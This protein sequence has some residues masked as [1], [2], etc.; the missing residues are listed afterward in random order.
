[1]S[2]SGLE[3]AAGRTEEF[4]RSARMNLSSLC[5]YR[6]LVEAGIGLAIVSL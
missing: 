2:M 1:M 6:Q 5:S 4:E 3:P